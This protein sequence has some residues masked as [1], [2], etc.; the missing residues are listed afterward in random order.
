[1]RYRYAIL[2]I[3]MTVLTQISQAIPPG[4]I[5]EYSDIP[6]VEV[7]HPVLNKYLERD[8]KRLKNNTE[9]V[10]A[11]SEQEML[12]MLPVQSGVWFAGCPDKDCLNPQGSDFEWKISDPDHIRC[13]TCGKIFPNEK[14]HANGTTSVTPPSGIPCIYPYYEENGRKVYIQAAIDYRKRF[15]FESIAKDLA[16]LYYRTGDEEYGRRAVLIMLHFARHYDDIAY[17]YDYP[18]TPVKFF[19]GTPAIDELKPFGRVTRWSWWYY[20][21]IP[22]NMIYAYDC[23]MT[24]PIFAQ[25]VADEYNEDFQT[26]M[27]D[28]FMVK[29]AKETLLNE[30]PYGNMSPTH[31]MYLIELARATG[32]SDF[33]HIVLNRIKHYMKISYLP[34]GNWCEAAVG[35]HQQSYS[36]IRSLVYRLSGFSDPEGFDSIYSEGIHLNNFEP[37]ELIKS[38][39]KYEK[40]F[41][42]MHTP[43]NVLTL[44]D[45]APVTPSKTL[46]SLPSYLI[47]YP[48]IAMLAGGTSGN[49]IQWYTEFTTKYG[50]NHN[51]LLNAVFFAN[52]KDLLSDLGYTHTHLRPYTTM[53]P[54]HNLVVADYA[55]Q[56]IVKPGGNILF[57]ELECPFLK[58]IAADG[59]KAYPKLKSYRRCSFM[60]PVGDSVY[61]ADFF[62]AG[63][64][65]ER[66]DYFFHG[67][68][69]K[70]E[71]L[72]ISQGNT[73]LQSDNTDIMPEEARRN[74]KTIR[75]ESDFRIAEQKYHVYG[76]FDKIKRYIPEKDDAIVVDFKA[77]DA[78]NLRIL[79]PLPTNG[80]TEIFTGRGPSHHNLSVYKDKK[81]SYRSFACLSLSDTNQKNVVL[82][83]VLDPVPSTVKKIT[84]PDKNAM[85]VQTA[86]R[87]DLIFKDKPEAIK[88][89][90]NGC[91]FI[92]RGRYGMLSI[93]K[94]GKLLNAYVADGTIEKI[95]DADTETA[96]ESGDTI[97][98]LITNS[99]GLHTM[100]LDKAPEFTPNHKFARI[101]L[102]DD[103]IVKGNFVNSTD[104]NSVKMQEE[105][106]II[107]QNGWKWDTYPCTDIPG[108][109]FLEVIPAAYT[110][111]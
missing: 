23:M 36:G 74:W 1:M 62:D 68:P 101:I 84:A 83:S 111:K 13:R 103:N 8:I 60:V 67:N 72:E 55:P 56:R 93:D 42:Q 104:G 66:L 98:C 10:M 73:V 81:P 22:H 25:T 24:N 16:T 85:I 3:V 21:D 80:A 79:F 46:T 107:N 45:T 96:I 82:K 86:E 43:N 102:K 51:D 50:H 7:E 106:G 95:T 92:V 100:Q 17:K 78:T 75:N 47:P 37:T 105:T 90:I 6:D 14:Y 34:G 30:E 18:F 19:N 76:Y 71:E 53:T 2:M 99:D 41:T 59:N 39:G 48:G 94:E 38:L 57:A 69:W 65:K 70:E 97:E 88:Y 58:I 5:L 12:K 77:N 4:I 64:N 63:G 28:K 49:P 35:Y 89:E 26:Q 29:A 15:Y 61:I 31:W 9:A 109:I 110:S 32:K 11:L 91:S 40:R 54:V 52:G 27:L 44:N 20:M 108:D 33:I 87:T